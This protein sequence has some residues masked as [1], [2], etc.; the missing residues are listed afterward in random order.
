MRI[1][2]G[3]GFINESDKGV[4]N[5]LFI[6]G[7]ARWQLAQFI[8]MM[9]SSNCTRVCRLCREL[10]LSKRT[11][12]LFQ[13]NRTPAIVG[14]KNSD[15]FS[16]P[17][18]KSAWHSPGKSWTARHNT[19]AACHN[20]IT[21]VEEICWFYITA[22]YTKH[23]QDIPFSWISQKLNT[24]VQ[25]VPGIP[26]RPSSKLEH[27]DTRLHVYYKHNPMLYVSCIC[28]FYTGKCTV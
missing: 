3:L 7:P 1:S 28:Y 25:H 20:A 24:C 11:M 17:V 10:V 5:N 21:V 15:S 4:Q 18:L 2:N 16:I 27:M 14:F 19:R 13:C 6:H 22:I 26:P 8:M 12:S 23:F 9:A